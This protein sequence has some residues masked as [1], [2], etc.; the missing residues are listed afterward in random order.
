M[1]VWGEKTLVPALMHSSGI[2]FDQAKTCFYYAMATYL[3]PD[4]LKRMPIL[5][6]IGAHG[7]GKT[8]LL[9]Q[10]KRI[11]KDPEFISAE[12]NPTLR[13][14]LDTALTAVI[15]EGD[16]VKE[17][18]L[19]KRYDKATSKISHKV[20]NGARSWLTV[21]SDIFGAT[22]IVRRIPF[23]DSATRSRSIVIKTGYKEGDYKITRIS[24]SLKNKM[25]EHVN[26]VSLEK[27]SNRVT[28]NWMPLQAIA[29][30]LGDKKW[31]EY[32]NKEIK[33]NVKVLKG[34]Q[35]YEPDQALLLVLKEKMTK[36]VKGTGVVLQEDVLLSEIRESLK[37][38]FEV[39]LKNPQIE[40]ILQD[41][42][43]KTVTPSGY[44][45]V[46]SNPKLLDRLLKERNL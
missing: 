14:K 46:K 43:F 44:P 7:T 38:E 20:A 40:E 5:A 27:A 32:S 26:E 30:Y 4:K 6:I 25:E 2:S 35:N 23:Q 28:D 22:I 39:N 37:S 16:K 15:D 41:L 45:K 3:L 24:D 19:I 13:D 18:Y 33:K 21:R 9:K 8:S 29:E 17:D 12:S 11:V 36:A 34:S 1:A 31:L 10:L 42:G